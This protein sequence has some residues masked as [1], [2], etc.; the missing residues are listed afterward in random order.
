MYLQR[1]IAYAVDDERLLKEED[2][3]TYMSKLEGDTLRIPSNGG[4]FGILCFT[5]YRIEARVVVDIRCGSRRPICTVFLWNKDPLP[6]TV[7]ELYAASKLHSTKMISELF[8]PAPR[9]VLRVVL[10]PSPGSQFM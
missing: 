5:G 3:P 7:R 10:V 4:L 8:V 9:I 1:K 6:Y 2:T